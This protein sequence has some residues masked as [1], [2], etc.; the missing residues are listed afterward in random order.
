MGYSKKQKAHPLLK[1]TNVRDCQLRVVAVRFMKKQS[2]LRGWWGALRVTRFSFFKV[3]LIC[4]RYLHIQR[5]KFQIS[6]KN[7]KI[8][9][10]FLLC[11][12]LLDVYHAYYGV[13]IGNFPEAQSQGEWG[14]YP[15][16][17]YPGGTGWC[18]TVQTLLT[19]SNPTCPDAI[20]SANMVFTSFSVDHGL[21][22]ME[23]LF[24]TLSF[25]AF[26]FL[27]R[28]DTGIQ[29]T[30]PLQKCICSYKPFGLDAE[31]L[32]MGSDNLFQNCV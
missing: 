32:L 6:S 15:L 19:P 24:L 31:L 2:S 13:P 10:G 1:V 3:F 29:L 30:L 8:W 17:Q 26:L 5:T 7:K 20:S 23:C 21:C 18:P 12:D 25:L 4:R 14:L 9:K 22:V 27:S 11:E 16:W 28:R